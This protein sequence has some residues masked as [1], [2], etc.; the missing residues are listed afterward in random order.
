VFRCIYF[1]TTHAQEAS[2]QRL[3]GLERNGD[4]MEGMA[5]TEKELHRKTRSEDK[6]R[7]GMDPLKGVCPTEEKSDVS[8]L[9]RSIKCAVVFNVLCK[10]SQCIVEL[11][12]SWPIWSRDL[13]PPHP[14]T[15]PP[16]CLATRDSVCLQVSRTMDLDSV[17]DNRKQPN[18]EPVATGQCM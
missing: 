1:V 17:V 18:P 12:P 10:G 11:C 5:E 3:L 6:G 2:K 8:G 4:Q 15:R 13:S 7:I 9:I 14:G 16:L